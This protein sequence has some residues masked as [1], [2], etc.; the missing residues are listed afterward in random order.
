MTEHNFIKREIDSSQDNAR[1][2]VHDP[3]E[4][5]R[6][7]RGL[8]SRNALVSAF[9]NAGNDLLLTSV[10]EVVPD[11]HALIL[12]CGGNA[13]MNRRFLESEKVIFV[14]AL[15]NVKIQ[16]VSNKVEPAHFEGRD[17]FRIAIPGEVLR[18]QRREYY[19]LATPLVNPLK[20]RI[21]VPDGGTEEVTLADISAGGVGIIIP[22][23]T[24]IE[25]S[26]GA[27][28]PGCSLELPGVGTAEFTLSVQN[29][30][31]TTLK[32]GSKSRRAGCKFVDIRPGMQSLIQR[33]IIKLERER[34]AHTGQER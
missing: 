30:W 26:I 16:W 34:I 32:N 12:D 33:Y 23:H 15:D 3:L 20:C 8:V 7:M 10:L 4:I 27:V 6:I 19:R 29:M 11:A 25:F 17:A 13:V 1:F 14:T 21:P 31:E 28:F 9:F 5:V 18:L 2:L 24:S 22:A